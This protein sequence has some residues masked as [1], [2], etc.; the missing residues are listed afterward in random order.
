[1]S[2]IIGLQHLTFY[3][4]T[5][6][7]SYL[8]LTYNLYFHQLLMYSSNKRINLVFHLLLNYFTEYKKGTSNFNSEWAIVFMRHGTIYAILT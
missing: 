2:L 5:K 7:T 3:S 1:V 8:S 4:R 6:D